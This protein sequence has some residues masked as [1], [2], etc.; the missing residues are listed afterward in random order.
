MTEENKGPGG[1]GTATIVNRTVCVFQNNDSSQPMISWQVLTIV[2]PDP[3]IDDYAQNQGNGK[4]NITSIGRYMIASIY[5]NPVDYPGPGGLTAATAQA[6]PWW[7][8]L[9]VIPITVP[10]TTQP[11]LRIPPLATPVYFY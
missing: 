8:P 5:G 2:G 11:N 10:P 9:A 7:L 4:W 3:S 1:G 6:M